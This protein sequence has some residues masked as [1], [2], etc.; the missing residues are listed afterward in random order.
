MAIMAE[1]FCHRRVTLSQ[2][3]RESLV[4]VIMWGNAVGDSLCITQENVTANL[5]NHYATSLQSN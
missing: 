4:K 3:K 5:G 1:I 2:S